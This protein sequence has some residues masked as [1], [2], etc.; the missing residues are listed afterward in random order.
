MRHTVPARLRV[1]S[2][3]HLSECHIPTFTAAA[4]RGCKGGGAGAGAAGVTD[5]WLPLRVTNERRFEQ[6]NSFPQAVDWW[7]CGQGLNHKHTLMTA[8]RIGAATAF[9]ATFESFE[10]AGNRTLRIPLALTLEQLQPA[11]Q[12]ATSVRHLRCVTLDVE[13]RLLVLIEA[14]ISK[15]ATAKAP[16]LALLLTVKQRTTHQI[17][18]CRMVNLIPLRVYTAS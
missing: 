6:S 10:R 17:C 12:S 5:I 7:R 11:R 16:K 18:S 13:G 15:L 2:C 3:P 14:M 1:T 4:A 8:S 9:T